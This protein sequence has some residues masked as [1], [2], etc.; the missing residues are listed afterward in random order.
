MDPTH[1]PL[2]IPPEQFVRRVEKG[3][4]FQVLDVR[5][6]QRLASG[7]VDIVPDERFFNLRGSLLVEMKDFGPTGLDKTL[8]LAVVC[9]FGRDSRRIARHLTRAGFDALSLQGG[10]SRWVHTLVARE[11]TPPANVDRLV[12]FDRIGKGALAYLAVSGDEAVVIDAP[13]HPEPILEAAREAG[14][15]IVAVADT[16]A[17]A[18][19]ISGGPALANEL[20]V[21]YHLHPAD[22][23]YPYDG[24]PGKLVIDALQD[25]RE[26]RVGGATLTALHMPGH[27]EGSVAY[28]IGD[29]TVLTGDFLFVASV[30]RPD[31]GERTE[32]WTG[33]LWHSLERARRE[34][35]ASTQ[36][37]PAHYASD[38]ERDGDR[39]VEAR[40]GAMRARNTPLAI[41][42]EA[43]FREWVQAR[44]GA[45][46]EQYRRIKAINVGLVRVDEAEADELEAGRN[47]CALG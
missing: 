2:E 22:N 32:E 25:G 42:H 43:D 19:Y 30:G 39:A 40:F 46:P 44:A 12:Q 9:G 45:F 37:L 24:T 23:S 33:S 18:D 31:L 21:P 26:L 6:A 3:E 34:W 4:P 20:G 29:E 47:E 8:P 7:R 13:R 15:R 1:S 28:R 35:P 17:H 36:V 41:E 27:T 16:H 10:M 38:K 11:L 14:A 5:A